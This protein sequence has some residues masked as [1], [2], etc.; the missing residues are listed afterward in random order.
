MKAV[1]VMVVTTGR[2]DYGLLFPL[3][4][5]MLEDK[6]FELQLVA[7][8]SHLSAFY[9]NTLEAIQKDGIQVQD[10]IEMTSSDDSEN[11]IC[12]AIAAGLGG[13]SELFHQKA[14]DLL[15]VLGDRYELLSVC[16]AAL[17]HKVLIAHI[18]GGEVTYGALDDPIRHALTKMATFHFPSI[19]AYGRRIIQMGES[20]D[21]V[22]VVGALGIDNIKIRSLLS[23]S[24]L[25]AHTG[26]DFEKGV[27]LMT[28][29]P[30]TLDHYE[31]AKQQVQQVLNAVLK[32]DLFTLVTMPNA[33]SAGK[34]I[35]QELAAY[36]QRFPHRIKLI[37]SLG[38]Q[39]YLSA[40][41][42]ARLMLG[43]SSSGILE[44]AS[45]KLPVVNI[46]DRQAGRFK[47]E[48]V[49]DC[50]CSESSILKALELAG[51]DSF[52]HSLRQL[53]N[54]YGDGNTASRII[55]KLA[56]VDMS[57]KTY[58]LKKEFQDLPEAEEF[59]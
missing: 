16:I 5:K 30:V 50:S 2:A 59:P 36:E 52:T 13:F 35:Y 22:F 38:Q 3:I 37:K 9:G 53:T 43:N 39:G 4:Q 14:P 25:K 46:G 19:E 33:D 20:R 47:P 54:P 48:N 34:V 6:R 8:G 45:F 12:H 21:R 31:S 10:T 40:M 51:S 32:T 58:L 18:H 49:I 27:A 29:H 23:P 42:Y 44:S 15:I 26:V 11:A 55:E 17:M 1:K 28:Y 41:N 57:D 7:T 24:E 56:S